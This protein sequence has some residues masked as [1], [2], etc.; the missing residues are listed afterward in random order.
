MEETGKGQVEK[1]LVQ[2]L[3][4]EI[5]FHS[6]SHENKLI[7]EKLVWPALLTTSPLP[8][9]RKMVLPQATMH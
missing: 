2:S 5:E 7:R 4:Q 8:F 3:A 1:A 9:I 6:P